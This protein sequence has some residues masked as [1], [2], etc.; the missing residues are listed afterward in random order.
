MDFGSAVPPPSP[1]LLNVTSIMSADTLSKETAGKRKMMNSGAWPPINGRHQS[2]RRE[3]TLRTGYLAGLESAHNDAHAR[4]DQAAGSGGGYAD[5][6]DD[7]GRGAAALDPA[8]ASSEYGL[9]RWSVATMTMMTLV[10]RSFFA[11]FTL[12]VVSHDCSQLGTN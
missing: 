11:D 8:V 6:D 7:H 3:L 5:R 1:G 12:H 10:S 4:A 9:G 2:F